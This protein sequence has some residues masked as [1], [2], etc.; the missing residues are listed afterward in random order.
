[1][2]L[3]VATSNPPTPT[4]SLPP[5][6]GVTATP[7]TSAPGPTHTATIVSTAIV[8]T[9]TTGAGSGTWREIVAANAGP[10]PRSDHTTVVDPVRQQLV[11]FGGLDKDAFGDTWIFDLAT[12]VWR[13]VPASG[14]APRFGHGA[15]YDAAN[16]RMLVVMG[17]GAG[18]FNDVWAFDPATSTWRELA[19]G[20]S[21]RPSIR[22]GSAG[23]YDQAGHRFFISH[24]F[25][26]QGRFDD[27]WTLDLTTE[28]WTKVTTSGPV[29]VK[30]C[31]TR[32]SPRHRS[33]PCRRVSGKLLP[34]V[35]WRAG[36]PTRS[37]R[38]SEL[39]RS[40]SEP[41]STAPVTGPARARTVF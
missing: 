38:F 4:E 32:A 10:A 36:P 24:G 37:D 17:Q 22:Y 39:P 29:P 41:S 16:R 7:A 14:P 9:P 2:E 21:D 23:A 11:V 19:L 6:P 26:T 15:V 31:L 25:T 28:T 5:L 3:P 30:R 27:T 18:F 13:E 8:G 34:C 40:T 33:R 1:M 35:T 20:S 12:R